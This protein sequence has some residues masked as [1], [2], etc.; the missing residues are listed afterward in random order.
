MKLS[1][2]ARNDLIDR[3]T[4]KTKGTAGDPLTR[5]EVAQVVDRTLAELGAEIPPVEAEDEP[6][7]DGDDSVLAEHDPAVDDG[8][9]D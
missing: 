6:V 5:E 2:E 7:E 4:A 9:A 1:D 3:V 8:E